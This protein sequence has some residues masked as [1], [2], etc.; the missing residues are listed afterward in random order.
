MEQESK[1]I[2]WQSENRQKVQ[3]LMYLVSEET[4]R[5]EHRKQSKG[6][7]TGVDGVTKEE[8]GERWTKT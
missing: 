1:G 8:Y 5:E 6:K 3:N 4:L 2:R 7:A